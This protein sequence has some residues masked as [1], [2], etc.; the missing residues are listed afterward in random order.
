[1]NTIKPEENPMLESLPG[2]D[3]LALFTVAIMR[4]N[5]PILLRCN[6]TQE[7][8]DGL[9]ACL[10]G[11]YDPL[12]VLNAA[13][14]EI[15]AVHAVTTGI[16]CPETLVAESRTAPWDPGFPWS[17]FM[18][19]IRY[20]LG[21]QLPTALTPN[22]TCAVGSQLMVAGLKEDTEFNGQ[23]GVCKG[24][25][26]GLYELLMESDRV[27]RLPPMNVMLISPPQPA[28]IPPQPTSPPT[29]SLVSLAVLPAPTDMLELSDEDAA[30]DN[31]GEGDDC[32]EENASCN[33]NSTATESSNIIEGEQNGE[34]NSARPYWLSVLGAA[35]PGAARGAAEDGL[36]SFAPTTSNMINTAAAAG[37]SSSGHASTT[38]TNTSTTT[39][40]GPTSAANAHTASPVVTNN[41]TGKSSIFE[42]VKRGAS[43]VSSIVT[44]RKKDV[45]PTPVA[46]VMEEELIPAAV[47]HKDTLT[48]TA[49]KLAQFK[50]VTS[51]PEDPPASEHNSGLSITSPNSNLTNDRPYPDTPTTDIVPNEEDLTPCTDDEREQA[52]SFFTHQPLH[53][54]H[55]PPL[56]HT[57]DD[58]NDSDES[59]GGDG[60]AKEDNGACA[61]DDGRGPPSRGICR[62]DQNIA[63]PIGRTFNPLATPSPMA[64]AKL[65]GAATAAATAAAAA[66]NEAKAAMLALNQAKAATTLLPGRDSRISS[67][68]PSALNSSS[69][70]TSTSAGSPSVR[71]AARAVTPTPPTQSGAVEVTPAGGNRNAIPHTFETMFA[72]ILEQGKRIDSQ[73]ATIGTVLGRCQLQ[74]SL[75]WGMLSDRMCCCNNGLR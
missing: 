38:T 11:L 46:E 13:Y 34:H 65:A 75:A 31:V 54:H 60:A 1:M 27:V 29:R 68:E 18:E 47:A 15:T 20:K 51:P 45:T 44:G 58:G 61:K 69:T 50:Q 25:E 59:V 40:I 32:E 41:S 52:S 56:Q 10:A 55:T 57:D 5:L 63:V 2:T 30:P 33:T 3:M 37:S 23:Y 8:H 48:M 9:K 53:P 72:I 19:M 24:F 22:E 64:A 12:P 17:A 49:A 6:D 26:D 35:A 28:T 21:G 71:R 66:L 39:T 70:S 14:A 7:L 4:V 73:Q 42:K 36:V 62:S 16:D 67:T 74:P 43:S